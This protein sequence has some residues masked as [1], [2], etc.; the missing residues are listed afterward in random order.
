MREIMKAQKHDRMTSSL[1]NQLSNDIIS[2]NKA[3]KGLND[4]ESLYHY[5]RLYILKLIIMKKI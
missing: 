2:E 1:L 5:V 4:R 3:L